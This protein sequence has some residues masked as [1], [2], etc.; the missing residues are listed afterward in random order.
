M[1]AYHE[2]RRLGDRL[3]RVREYLK[4]INPKLA[5]YKELKAEEKEL[6]TKIGKLAV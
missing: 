3:K 4:D 2:L 1:T 5:K 6:L